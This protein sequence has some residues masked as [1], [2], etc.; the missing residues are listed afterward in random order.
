MIDAATTATANSFSSSSSSND[1]IAA[2]E[3]KDDNEAAAA[4]VARVYVANEEVSEA[5]APALA[6]FSMFTDSSMSNED[7]VEERGWGV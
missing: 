2:D 4:V 3:D 1:D 5:M 6:L 7:I